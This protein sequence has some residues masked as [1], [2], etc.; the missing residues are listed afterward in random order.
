MS[1]RLHPFLPFLLFLLSLFS[2]SSWGHDLWIERQVESGG[3]SH[4]LFYGHEG[5]AHAGAK[6][7]E[8]KPENLK[9]AICFNVFGQAQAAEQGRT[10]PVKLKGDCAATWFLLSSGYWSKTP[11][12][13]RNLPKNEAGAVIASWLSLESVKRVERWG[14]AFSRPLTQELELVPLENPLPL[15]HGEKLQLQAYLLGKPMAGVTVA[16]FGK[17]R[18]TTGADGRINIRLN[19]TGLQLIQA[20]LE[21]QL[22]DVRA[23]KV[24]R[25]TTLQFEIQ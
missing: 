25:A 23:D 3:V 8:Y 9:K 1:A 4:C 6:R 11:Y 15:K 21:Q 20:S 22:D 7:L 24:I 5:T 10:Y 17:P 19:Q 16:Y 12:G 14:G 18:G 2:V 13:T